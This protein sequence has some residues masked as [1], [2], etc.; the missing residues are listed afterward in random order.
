MIVA[1]RINVAY[2]GIG[3]ARFA[4][5]AIEITCVDVERELLIDSQRLTPKVQEHVAQC[6]ACQWRLAGNRTA[7]RAPVAGPYATESSPRSERSHHHATA[8]AQPLARCSG[9]TAAFIATAV[10]TFACHTNVTKGA[11]WEIAIRGG[12]LSGYLAHLRWFERCAG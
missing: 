1:G 7:E 12:V 8:A 2:P 4:S 9:I 6:A 10:L 5:S 3:R 11:S